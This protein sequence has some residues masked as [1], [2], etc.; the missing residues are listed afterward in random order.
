MRRFARWPVPQVLPQF[1]PPVS[2][3]LVPKLPGAIAALTAL[4]LWSLPGVPA[5]LAQG[6]EPA[7][8]PAGSSNPEEDVF[9][10]ELRRSPLF[11]TAAQELAQTQLNLSYRIEQAMAGTDP[12]SVRAASG[13]T[14]IHLRQVERF[15]ESQVPQPAALCAPRSASPA[16]PNPASPLPSPFSTTEEQV[17]CG[18]WASVADLDDLL[19]LLSYRLGTLATVAAVKPLPLVTGEWVVGP[20]GIPVFERGSL[21]EPAPAL[22]SPVPPL[23]AVG[24]RPFDRPAKSALGDYN[25]PL[26]PAIAP[27]ASAQPTI[28]RLT[29]RL[30]QLQAA[31]GNQSTTLALVDPRALTTS[32]NPP[33]FSLTDGERSAAADFLALPHTGLSRLLPSSAY[34][35]SSPGV[36]NRLDPSAADRLPFPSLLAASASVPQITYPQPF[37]SPDLPL[38]DPSPRLLA[39]RA[40]VADPDP[41]Q[42]RLTLQVDDQNRLNLVTADLDYGFVLPLGEVPLEALDL[43]RLRQTGAKET[44][45]EVPPLPLDLPTFAFLLTY[46]PPQTL[47]ELQGDR[48]RILTGKQEKFGLSVPLSPTVP[49]VLNHTYLVRSIQ[50]EVPEVLRTGRFL[51]DRD[52][53]YRQLLLE[54]PSRDLLLA[55]Q[56]VAQQRDGSYTLRWRVLGQFPDPEVVDLGQYVD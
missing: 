49:L 31:V 41:F 42:P 50:F 27:L 8:S 48:N 15:L 9:P 19:G 14:L 2:A 1:T 44:D 12:N 34:Q 11:W 33:S 10:L 22:N 46:Q 25:P 37:P 17:Y 45:D 16:D 39:A 40:L 47:V 30:R 54:M 56:P 38:P 13:Q 29:D 55:V 24:S 3:P 28:Q 35:D 5:T 20:G 36:R 6:S 51:T 32:L 23:T 52:R 26:D 53:R 21:R 7:S 4:G 43:N 18:L